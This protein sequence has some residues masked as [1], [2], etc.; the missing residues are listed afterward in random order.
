MRLQQMRKL[1]EPQQKEEVEECEDGSMYVDPALSNV[2]E[3][4]TRIPVSSH[5]YELARCLAD[6]LLNENVRCGSPAL[7]A[8]NCATLAAAFSRTLRNLEE[9]VRRARGS[10]K[11]DGS[12]ERILGGVR[13]RLRLWAESVDEEEG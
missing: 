6:R 12:V 2:L 1:E 9:A 7:A 8:V 13:S 4:V 3:V 10:G 11:A 5:K